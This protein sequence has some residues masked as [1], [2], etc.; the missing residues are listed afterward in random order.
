MQ[1]DAK[2]IRNPEVLAPVHFR[3][4]AGN[5]ARATL[6]RGEILDAVLTLTTL[7]SAGFVLLSLHRIV[8]NWTVT[9][10]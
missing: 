5:R 2:A 7:G 9:G 4:W 3:E 8:T 6:T 1:I 10:F